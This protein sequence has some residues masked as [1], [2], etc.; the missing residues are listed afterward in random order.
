MP[1]HPYREFIIR[2]LN[3]MEDGDPVMFDLFCIVLR[4]SG[5]NYLRYRAERNRFWAAQG[6][7]DFGRLTQGLVSI[8]K[9]KAAK[10]ARPGSVKE[11]GRATPGRSKKG[12][13]GLSD[14]AQG[15]RSR[16]GA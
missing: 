12:A 7:F 8:K 15:A 13:S 10:V 6:R 16:G 4:W 9:Q 11:K 3:R 2:H 14:Q 1:Y 5:K